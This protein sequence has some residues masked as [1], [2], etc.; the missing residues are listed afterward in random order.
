LPYSEVTATLEV[1]TRLGVEPEHLARLRLDLDYA[2][3]VAGALLK[4]LPVTGNGFLVTVDYD[5]S[6]KAL[7]R[8]CRCDWN[9]EDITTKNFLTKRIGQHEVK[10][11][12]FYFNRT[13]ILEEAI[14]EMEKEGYRPAE[15][16]E[17]LAYG[18]KNPDEQRK[19]PIVALGSVWRYWFGFR[20]VA[21]LG[22]DGDERGLGLGCFGDEWSEYCR[23]LAVREL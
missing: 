19:Y 15:F 20:Y 4:G 2:K 14:A 23:F 13:V 1:L 22:G 17:L 8:E 6:V 5:L 21:Y 3:L 11:K 16:H 9:N 18:I 10:M 7:V 12:L